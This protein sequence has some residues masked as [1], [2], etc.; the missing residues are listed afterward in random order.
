RGAEVVAIEARDSHVAKAEFVKAAL[1]L[2]RLTIVQ[3]NVRDVAS[4][5][6][7]EFDVVLCL[8]LLYHLDGRGACELMHDLRRIT[9]LFAI[10][11]T[12]ISLSDRT[13]FTHG[14]QTY[15]GRPSPEVTTRPG[16][17]VDVANAFWLTRP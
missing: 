5:A 13:S 11:E 3:G 2:D 1:G 6:S 15:W 12:Q 9:K 7:G 8:G 14:G 17:A 10:V 16:A 4:L